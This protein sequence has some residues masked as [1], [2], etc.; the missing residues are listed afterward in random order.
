MLWHLL[1]TRICELQGS[2]VSNSLAW[3]L[4]EDDLSKEPMA[5]NWYIR[6]LTSCLL[7]YNTM[8]AWARRDAIEEHRP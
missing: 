1:F 7:L 4:R 8:A 5:S 6:P 3:R 2:T